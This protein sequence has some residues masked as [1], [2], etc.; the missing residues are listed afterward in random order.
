MRIRFSPFVFSIS[1]ILILAITACNRPPDLPLEPSIS[2][3]NVE[4]EILNQGDPL[5]E[6]NELR[7]TFN[8]SDGDGDLGLDGNEGSDNQGPYR[9][10]F[11]VRDGN[12]FVE[13][14]DRPT[15]PPFTCL[16]YVIEDREN[17]D[18][19][20]DG[21]F[22]D[23][24][25]IEFN[26]AQYN[27]EVDFLVKDNG[28]FNEI[29]MRAQ[30]LF[31]ANQQTL[32]GITFDGRF[33]CLSTQDN[34]CDFISGNDRP[35]EGTVTYAM[36]SALFLP[37]FRTDTIKLQFKIRDRALNESNIAETPEFTLQGIQ[38]TN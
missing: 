21:D 19:N 34:P 37:V 11:L 12:R 36:N 14:G 15:D 17:Q 4:F 3:E 33:P 35:I 5:F 6:Q 16:D 9:N 2:F 24:L 27:I 32:C 29:D 1:A 7:L 23:T 28:H 20:N 22:A 13:F 10:Y 8:V 18:I 31:S 26:P 38:I 30:P 25:R